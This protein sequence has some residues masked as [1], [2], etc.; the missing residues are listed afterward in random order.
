M[1]D[2]MLLAKVIS[3]VFIT[4]V[5]VNTFYSIIFTSDFNDYYNL[6][7]SIVSENTNSITPYSWKYAMFVLSIISLVLEGLIIIEYFMKN[8]IT[9]N[10][11]NL[12]HNIYLSTKLVIYILY[13]LVV[14][15]LL[16]YGALGINVCKVSPINTEL[17]NTIYIISIIWI[18][19]SLLIILTLSVYMLILCTSK[20]ASYQHEII[21]P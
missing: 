14:F 11:S 21:N 19:I 1:E 8:Y 15:G 4:I 7:C 9:N 16:S 20:K 18:I 2:V 12:S 10:V 3:T 6:N 13:T 17:Y 5:L